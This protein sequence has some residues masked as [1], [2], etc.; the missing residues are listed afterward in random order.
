MNKIALE[1]F[2]KKI[3]THVDMYKESWNKKGIIEFKNER[4]AI[5]NK[6]GNGT[7]QFII[8]IDTLLDEGY[9]I[10]GIISAMGNAG[11]NQIIL[12]K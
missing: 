12:T 3:E 7:V 9:K 1:E 6:R 10:D 4:M 2:D 8:A 5:V 11:T